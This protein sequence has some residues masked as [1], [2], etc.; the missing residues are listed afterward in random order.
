MSKDSITKTESGS[1]IP[2][3]LILLA[4]IIMISAAFAYFSG[5]NNAG[6]ELLQNG[7]T[8]SYQHGDFRTGPDGTVRNEDKLK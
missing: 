5:E 6:D 8:P 3:I 4:L 1:A 7:A 2:V